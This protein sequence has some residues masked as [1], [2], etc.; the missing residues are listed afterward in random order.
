V[1]APRPDARVPGERVPAVSPA[2]GARTGPVRRPDAV[3]LDAPA[4]VASQ[5]AAARRAAPPDAGEPEAGSE[6][7]DPQ[8]SNTL[9]FGGLNAPGLALGASGPIPPDTTG[10][11]GT[12]RYVEVTNDDIAVYDR[13]NLGL[14]GGPLDLAAFAGPLD[15]PVV[16]D[17][18]H[19][20]WAFGESAAARQADL[21]SVEARDFT[22]PDLDGNMHSLSDYRGKKVFLH[23]W[24][25]Y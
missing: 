18:E 22:L 19:A 23:S 9:V 12:T 8:A 2:T 14:V 4:A 10:A 13:S 24:A 20:V 21:T 16:R 7:Q 1:A 17:E 15:C 11:I 5:K 25:S 3:G 6:A